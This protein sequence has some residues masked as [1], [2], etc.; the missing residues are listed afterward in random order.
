VRTVTIGTDPGCDIV[1][2]DPYASPRHCMLIQVLPG[3]TWSVRD[4]G[5]TNG[6]GIERLGSPGARLSAGSTGLLIAGDVLVVGRTRMPPF[7]PE[8]VAG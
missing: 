4:L 7:T 6:T 5:S 2:D 1:V 3:E 8:R